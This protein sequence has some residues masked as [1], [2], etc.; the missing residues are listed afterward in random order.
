[1]LEAVCSGK[2]H[3]KQSGVCMERH[4]LV[5]ALQVAEGTK[6]TISLLGRNLHH[7]ARMSPGEML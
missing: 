6:S 3:K 1:M 7:W 5:L 4:G 2:D